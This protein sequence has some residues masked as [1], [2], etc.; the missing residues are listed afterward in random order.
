MD[1][2]RDKSALHEKE[3]IEVLKEELIIS[4]E[5]IITGTVTAHKTVDTEIE[6]HKIPLMREE[7]NIE[8][9]YINK[10]ID[11]IPETRVEGDVT[12][13]PV[14]RE[15][16]IVTKILMLMEE[17]HLT[18]KTSTPLEDIEVP[19]RKESVEIKRQDHTTI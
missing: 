12:I 2:E 1:Q 18:K 8:H 4:K 7:I 13:I 6:H 9:V 19:I 11:S 10:K 16:A 3:I 14:V 17:V 5:K 15:V